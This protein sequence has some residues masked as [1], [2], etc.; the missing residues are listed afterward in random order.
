MPSSSPVQRI[1][2]YA[3]RAD[4]YPVYAGLRHT[5]VVRDEETGIF[6]V[7]TYWAVRELLHDPRISS[8]ARNLAPGANPLLA[9]D[10]EES[11]LPPSFIR[12]DPP[13]HDRLRRL[14]MRPFGPPHS[15]RRIHDMRG[16]LS[17]IVTGLVDGLAGRG[18]FDVVDDFAYPFPVTVI[19]RLLGVPKEDE[20]RFRG[21]VDAVVAGLSPAEDAAEQRRSVR[22]SRLELGQYLA[23]LIEEHQRHP[24]DDMLSQLAT[25]EGPEGRLSLVELISTAVLLLI[26]GHE[27]TVNLITNG[28]LTLL[29]HPEE[30]RRLREDPGTAPGLVEE[31]LRYEPPVHVLPQ[32]TTLA[33]IELAGTVIPKGAAVWLLLAS[34]NRDAER[35]A[36][37]D[38]FDPARPDNQHLGFGFGVHACFGAPLARLEAQTALSELVRRLENPR[39]AEDPPP[40]RPSPVLRGPRHLRVA[41]D[42][43]AG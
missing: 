3:N 43:L 36:D 38:R 35:F 15:P 10:T 19:C 23:G 8:D 30:L 6:L 34:A 31:L 20:P 24:G 13:D 1:T 28:M 5:P 32:R 16:E 25:D 42:G 41:F 33:E 4:P 26:A 11:T 2:D 22:R 7:T 29:R 40:Y 21:L 9:S 12:L 39:L 17:R 37:P 27:T 14:A 18:E